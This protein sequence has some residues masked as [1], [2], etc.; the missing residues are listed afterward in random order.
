MRAIILAAGDGGRMAG[1]VRGGV[2]KPL[3]YTPNGRTVL[4]EI[5]GAMTEVALARGEALDVVI[6][7]GRYASELQEE[8]RRLSSRLEVFYNTDWQT[9]DNLYSLSLVA[10]RIEAPTVVINGD[11]M[12][13]PYLLLRLMEK[14]EDVGVSRLVREDSDHAGVFAVGRT[15]GAERVRA[16]MAKLLG[17]TGEWCF[18]Q[19]HLFDCG[20]LGAVATV[21]VPSEFILE[22]DTPDDCVEMAKRGPFRWLSGSV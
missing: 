6:V 10:D 3:L 19:R 8:A 7:G 16:V 13:A 18:Q 1:S 15:E 21:G 5:V 4:A 20:E 11:T 17:R 22:L 14:A 9:S 12:V 2:A